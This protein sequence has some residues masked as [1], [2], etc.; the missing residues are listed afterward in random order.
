MLKKRA[1][2]DEQT[3]LV[4]VAILIVVALI[5]KLINVFNA[6]A[7][8]DTGLYLN[9]AVGYFERG[10]LTPLMWR[11]NPEWNILTGSGSGYG[12][13]ILIGWLRVFGV[14]VLS[15][16][17]LM[18]VVG[19][20]NLPVIY[21]LAKRYYRNPQA[22]LWAM[23]F[24]ALSG[25]FA[26]T[27]YV[28]MD[29]L[30][31]LAC[32]LVLWLHLEAVRRGVWW[33]HALVGGALVAAL[34]VHVLAA[35]YASGI[36]LHHA[37]QHV[38]LMQRQ[39]RLV[40]YSPAVAFGLGLAL[41]TVAYYAHHIAPNPDLYFLIP[42]NC[43]ICTPRSLVKEVVRWVEWI[44]QQPLWSLFMV[45]MA[46]LTALQRRT[47]ADQ[48]CLLLLGGA[49]LGLIILNPPVFA[50]YTGHLLPLLSLLVGGLFAQGI[51]ASRPQ[52]AALRGLGL[53]FGVTA[54]VIVGRGTS[55]TY[56]RAF[57]R[58]AYITE[59]AKASHLSE[60][61]YAAAVQFIRA[62]VP[63][64]ATVVGHETFYID[65]VEYRRFLS[66]H[67][68][69]KH[70]LQYRRETYFDLWQREQPQVFIGD[71]R[72]DPEV[73]RYITWRGGFV[74]VVPKLWVDQSLVNQAHSLSVEE[75]S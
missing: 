32:S 13:F 61:E 69:E 41:A 54:I 63:T 19:L 50:E 74:E 34:E 27:F 12:V 68:I 47:P 38:R 53:A 72:L 16:H 21:L 20:L 24:F 10:I 48:G 25:T 7:H 15:G 56:S 11:Y 65:L 22:G 30:N 51:R 29:A 33:L 46:L 67:G 66:Q 31:I 35:Y 6:P 28:R 3:A 60:A 5:F 14:S 70:G 9:I 4:G 62:H 57:I 2:G 45:G 71:A 43:D 36:G 40:V 73:Q 64:S 55:F 1:L 58:A 17:L 26:I 18:Y 52:F 37:Y 75:S 42:N 44:Q 23:G 59:F 49:Y 39:R 8:W